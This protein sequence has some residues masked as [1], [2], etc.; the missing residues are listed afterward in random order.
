MSK[1]IIAMLIAVVMMMAFFT[2]CGDT[3]VAEYDEGCES[4]D[5]YE[6]IDLTDEY[7]YARFRGSDEVYK[8]TS[9]IKQL[10]RDTGIWMY[11]VIVDGKTYATEYY[12][13]DLYSDAPASIWG[14]EEG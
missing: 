5:P 4:R 10:D 8:I 2:A 11:Y 6:P 14:G 9:C 13:I 3:F 1:K 12:T 7:A